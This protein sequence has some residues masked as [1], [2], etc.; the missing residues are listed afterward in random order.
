ME[1]PTEPLEEEP[2]VQAEEPDDPAAH[3]KRTSR[4][5]TLEI[6]NDMI[7]LV[8]ETQGGDLLGRIKGLRRKVEAGFVTDNQ[9]PR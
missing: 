9:N 7:D 3:S 1:R 5:A 4:A 2:E 8:D 6:A